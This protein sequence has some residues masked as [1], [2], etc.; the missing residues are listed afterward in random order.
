MS[1]A[2]L[3]EA[4][5]RAPTLEEIRTWPAVVEVPEA[6]RAYRIS[7]SHGYALIERGEFPAATIRVGGRLRVLTASI[8]SS[9]TGGT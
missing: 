5:T 4:A 1:R 2:Q 8:V 3:K 7:R 9:L 6:C